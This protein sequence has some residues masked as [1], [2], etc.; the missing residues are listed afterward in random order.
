MGPSGS[1][2]IHFLF[3]AV[4]QV[5][6][7]NSRPA[8]P[9]DASLRSAMEVS[10]LINEA[11]QRRNVL[12]RGRKSSMVAWESTLEDVLEDD[13]EEE[14]EDESGMEETVLKAADEEGEGTIEE[15]GKVEGLLL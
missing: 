11:D 10:V 1:Q 8:S 5:V 9:D 15:E 2:T 7:L 14:E 3:F 13:G 4:L 12:A 6:M